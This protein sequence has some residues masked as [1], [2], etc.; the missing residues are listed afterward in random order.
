MLGSS[1]GMA[2]PHKRGGM[3]AALKDESSGSR[4][5]RTVLVA[6]ANRP[7]HNRFNDG[8]CDAKGRLLAGTM[9]NN[10]KE[11]QRLYIWRRTAAPGDCGRQHLQR[12][13]LSPDNQY[14]YYVDTPSGFCGATAM[15]WKQAQSAARRR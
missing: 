5:A 15:I 7:P 2:V 6:D 14:L 13:R 11:G 9:D 10:G 8:K 4:R 12:H 3:V 1:L